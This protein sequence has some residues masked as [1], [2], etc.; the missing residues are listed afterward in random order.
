MPAGSWTAAGPPW[1]ARPR[2][3]ALAAAPPPLAKERGGVGILHQV[4]VCPVPDAGMDTASHRGFARGFFL[5]SAAMRSF[6]QSC[7]PD[8]PGGRRSPL[9]RCV[10]PSSSSPVCRP[11]LVITAEADVLR[12]EGEAYANKLRAAGVPVTAVRYRGII[13]DFV[14]LDALRGTHAARSAIGL[15][16][17]TLRRALAKN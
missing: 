2:G 13:H 9:P 11:A 17:E 7:V 14:M 10:P 16:V 1:P 5:G 12:D 3:P 4:L 15:A 8:R 6:W